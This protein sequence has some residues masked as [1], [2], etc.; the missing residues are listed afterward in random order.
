MSFFLG[1]FFFLRLKQSGGTLAGSCRGDTEGAAAAA[2]SF[3]RRGGTL[4]TAR[5]LGGVFFWVSHLNKCRM[6][7]PP[8][9]PAP[10]RFNMAFLCSH[11]SAFLSA[12]VLSS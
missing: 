4:R 9:N 3:K 8:K 11:L 12:M 1:D 5:R 10:P 7:V 2:G 6:M